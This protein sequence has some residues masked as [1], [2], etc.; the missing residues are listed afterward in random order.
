MN[1]S[2]LATDLSLKGQRILVIEDSPDAR[3][4]YRRSIQNAGGLVLAVPSGAEAWGALDGFRP[5]LIVCDIGLPHE[6]GLS[7]MRKFREREA[8]SGARVRAL[9]VTAFHDFYD[10]ARRA[11]FDAWLNKPTTGKQLVARL[12]QLS[13]VQNN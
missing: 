6:N 5:D 8:K 1:A 2:A 11:G 7:F 3:V 10:E 12:S 13:R 9:A 4:L